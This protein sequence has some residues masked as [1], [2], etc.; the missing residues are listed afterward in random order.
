MKCSISN[1]KIL[2]NHIISWLK[3]QK[4]VSSFEKRQNSLFVYFSFFSLCIFSLH[5]RICCAIL[6]LKC[7]VI[8]NII[9]TH[10]FAL[11]RSLML[12]SIYRLPV[13]IANMFIIAFVGI[14]FEMSSHCVETFGLTNDGGIEPFIKWKCF[15]FNEFNSH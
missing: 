1:I 15:K 11:S 9:H 10:M 14:P 5:R 8:I 6:P 7:A 3:R 2:W 12:A 13:A 4:I